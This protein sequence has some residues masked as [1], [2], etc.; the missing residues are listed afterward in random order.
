M[1]WSRPTDYYA[2]MVKSDGHMAKIKEQLMHEQRRIEE[3]E[4][5]CGPRRPECLDAKAKPVIISSSSGSNA[6]CAGENNGRLKETARSCKP[7][8]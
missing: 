4:E 2:E 1:P 3:S 7:R 6:W 8:G 5:R